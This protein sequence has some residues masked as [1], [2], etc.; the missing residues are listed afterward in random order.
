MYAFS[1]NRVIVASCVMYRQH[2][3]TLQHISQH[4][5]S[6]VMEVKIVHVH[7]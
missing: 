6:M 4:I 5:C 2:N 3:K 7:L 1:N